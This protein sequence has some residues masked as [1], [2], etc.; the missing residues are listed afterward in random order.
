MTIKIEIECDRLNCSESTEIDG[1]RDIDI[2]SRGW[3]ID[4]N[5]DFHYCPRCWAIIQKK[6]KRC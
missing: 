2:E 5:G 1:L 6:K 3:G 4:Y